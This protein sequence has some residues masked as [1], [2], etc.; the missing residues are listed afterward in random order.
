MVHS[1]L[2]DHPSKIS[3]NAHCRHLAQCSHGNKFMHEV[4]VVLYDGISFQVADNGGD[5][6]EF[7]RKDFLLYPGWYGL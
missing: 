3:A 1:A 5:A 4:Q 2:H 7:Q 6:I